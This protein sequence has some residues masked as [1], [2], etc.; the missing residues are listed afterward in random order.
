VPTL[1]AG[2]GVQESPTDGRGYGN[3][4]WFELEDAPIDQRYGRLLDFLY[5]QCEHGLSLQNC[6]GPQ[7]YHLDDEERQRYGYGY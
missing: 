5:P 2:P 6:Y 1:S 4:A 3:H 7:H